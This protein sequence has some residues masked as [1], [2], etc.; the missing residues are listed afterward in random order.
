MSGEDGNG[1]L[2]FTPI[3]AMVIDDDYPYTIYIGTDIG[4]FRKSKNKNSWTRFSQ[5]LPV[6]SIYDMRLL[7]VNNQKFLRVVTH[8]R[9]MWETRIRSR[10]L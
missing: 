9:G 4:V 3:N 7:K 5:G 8:G 6:C 10:I 2:P 1:K